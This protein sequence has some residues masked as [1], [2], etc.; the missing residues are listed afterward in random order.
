ML[1]STQLESFRVEANDIPFQILRRESTVSVNEQ[2]E[3][4]ITKLG[5]LPNHQSYWVKW[6]TSGKYGVLRDKEGR[7]GQEIET[8]FTEMFFRVISNP[9]QVDDDAEDMVYAEVFIKEGDELTSIGLDSVKVVVKPIKLTITPNGATL[10]PGNGGTSVIKLYVENA[11]GGRLENTEEF[12][13][14]YEWGTRGDYG[15]FNGYSVTE[16]TDENVVRYIAL[17]E[18]VEKAE[19]EIFVKVFRIEKGTTDEK[20][21]GEAKGKVK[22]ENDDNYKIIQL[23]IQVQTYSYVISSRH[24]STSVMQVSFPKQDDYEAYTVRFYGFRRQLRPSLE[25]RGGSW[26]EGENMPNSLNLRAFLAR[27][28]YNVTSPENQIGVFVNSGTI[29]CPISVSCDNGAVISNLTSQ[30]GMVEVKIKLKK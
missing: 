28:P 13:Y 9:S 1:N 23:P 21:F 29:D 17:D 2:V 20:L 5:Q 22:I 11:N 19:E 16:N 3:L 26:K 6:K 18:D 15:M 30:G 7:A 8:N 24:G 25:G 12:E 27:S 10:S 4:K 14:R